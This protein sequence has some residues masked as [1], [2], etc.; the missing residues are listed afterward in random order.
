MHAL[1]ACIT[2]GRCAVGALELALVRLKSCPLRDVA[3]L[4]QIRTDKHKTR[5]RLNL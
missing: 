5:H 3:F 2:G 1:C 4:L